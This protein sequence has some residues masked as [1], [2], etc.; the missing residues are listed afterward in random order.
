MTNVAINTK[1][2]VSELQDLVHHRN[3]VAGGVD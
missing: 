3:Q 1:L 2:A